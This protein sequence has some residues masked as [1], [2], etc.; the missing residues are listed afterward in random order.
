MVAEFLQETEHKDGGLVLV[1]NV[2][3]VLVNVIDEDGKRYYVGGIEARGKSTT[4]GDFWLQYYKK[5]S[6]FR[7][8]IVTSMFSGVLPTGGKCNRRN[9]L[10]PSIHTWKEGGLEVAPRRDGQGSKV[11]STLN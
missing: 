6:R 1:S 5:G 8:Y 10:P 3:H 7:Q 4:S 9:G 2:V 11:R